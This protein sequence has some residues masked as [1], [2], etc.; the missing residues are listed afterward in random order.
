MFGNLFIL[1]PTLTLAING[2]Q[3]SGIPESCEHRKAD[4]TFLFD[5]S[6]SIGYIKEY[7]YI[8]QK[9][10]AI[11][12]FQKVKTFAQNVVKELENDIGSEGIR[13]S[14]A[15]FATDFTVVSDFNSDSGDT[16]TILSKIEN[17][18]YSHKLL[19]HT[20]DEEL[21]VNTPPF[22]LVSSNFIQNTYIGEAYVKV[23]S[24]IFNTAISKRQGVPK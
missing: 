18:Q 20:I 19:G 22:N 17:M 15:K 7:S 8:F 12:N 10:R 24:D 1:L 14:L 13:I 9:L 21:N 23:N 2:Q 3:I 4:I 5:E 6:T 16:N 11:E